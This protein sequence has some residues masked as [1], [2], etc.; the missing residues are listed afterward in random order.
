MASPRTRLIIDLSLWEV[1][2]AF[3]LA[4][5]EGVSAYRTAAA[6]IIGM[7]AAGTNLGDNGVVASAALA[8]FDRT[9]LSDAKGWNTLAL[10][11]H[12]EGTRVVVTRRAYAT[13]Y[14]AGVIDLSADP[15]GILSGG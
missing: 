10:D 8:Y 3:A 4:E 14:P 7:T 12:L 5:R 2:A 9:Y 11:V 6:S 1:D 13:A 15:L